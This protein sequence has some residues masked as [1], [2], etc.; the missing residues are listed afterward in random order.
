[1]SHADNVNPGEL[2]P[3]PVTGEWTRRWWL[4]LSWLAVVALAVAE[5]T[6]QVQHFLWGGVPL[7]GVS[8]GFG[9]S[10]AFGS[11][12]FGSPFDTPVVSPD[13]RTLY[14]PSGTNSIT[15]V[16]TATRKADSQTLYVAVRSGLETF[17]VGLPSA[18]RQL[19][20]SNCGQGIPTCGQAT[21][22]GPH[23]LRCSE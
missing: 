11:G 14:V 2:L 4:L 15:P 7:A 12:G 23:C 21:E 1:M 16:D 13:G 9:T 17:H 3:S 5:V 22:P 8:P 10:G 20:L 6:V 19:L 18:Q